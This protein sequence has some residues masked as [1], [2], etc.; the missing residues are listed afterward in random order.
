MGRKVVLGLIVLLSVVAAVWLIETPF[1][2]A[3]LTPVVMAQTEPPVAQGEQPEVTERGLSGQPVPLTPGATM[4]GLQPQN[5][6]V[7][8]LPKLPGSPP[9]PKDLSPIQKQEGAPKRSPDPSEM[10]NAYRA[11]PGGAEAIEGARRRGALI[12]RA[13]IPQ[14]HPRPWSVTVSPEV[15]VVPD[16]QNRYSELGEIRIG[17]ISLR[18]DWGNEY[19]LRSEFGYYDPRDGSF[20]TAPSSYVEFHA[21]VPRDGWYM[22]N[23]EMELVGSPDSACAGFG[24]FRVRAGLSGGYSQFRDPLF[25]FRFCGRPRPS[26]VTLPYLVELARGDQSFFLEIGGAYAGPT[27]AKLIEVSLTEFER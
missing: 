13:G 3:L 27:F 16:P 14:V 20:R 21:D 23:F 9:P 25:G 15:P 12:P 26:R 8:L 5:L 11:L 7:R 17:G 2:S 18:A 24:L 1:M 19:F 10:L 6:N 4:P 22:L